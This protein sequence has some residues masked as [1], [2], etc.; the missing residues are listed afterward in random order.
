MKDKNALLILAGQV[1]GAFLLMALLSLFIFGKSRNF[2]DI[3]QITAFQFLLQV[4]LFA[5]FLALIRVFSAKLT[6]FLTPVLLSFLWLVYLTVFSFYAPV[7]SLVFGALLIA[8]PGVYMS[9]HERFALR[10]LEYDKSRV[11]ANK[12]LIHAN[13]AMFLAILL[14]LIVKA[15]LPYTPY[16]GRNL[17]L[18][19]DMHVLIGD[20]V[21]YFY[22]ALGVMAGLIVAYIF[23][24]NDENRQANGKSRET[25]AIIVIVLVVLFQVVTLSRMMVY[26]TMTLQTPSYDFGIFTQMFY[27]MRNFEGMVT[28]LERGYALNHN[29]VHISPI[30][31]LLLP[32]FWIFPRPETLQILQ[33]IVV[34]TGVIPLY[35]IGKEFQ[36]PPMIRS[37]IAIIYI[38]SPALISS[39]F[40][41]LHENCFLAPLI[42]F[43]LYFGIKKRTIPFFIS[44]LLLLL[45]KEDAGIYLVFIGL[46]FIFGTEKKDASRKDVRLNIIHGSGAIL[47]AILY[48][49][50]AVAYLNNA[51]TGAMLWRY[52]N[53]NGYPELG[54][55]GTLP[56]LF[57]NPSYLLS[58]LFQPS[59]VYSLV[60]IFATVGFFPFFVRNMADYFLLGPLIVVN[61]ASNYYWQ[62]QF[63]YQYF[64]GS[65]VLVIFLVL[66]SIKENLSLG[67][68]TR[69]NTIKHALY[70][71]A[72]V[73]LAISVMAGLD[74][75]FTRYGHI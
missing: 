20:W 43:V 64:Y 17:S 67:F 6:Y 28:T 73:A 57:Q 70:S 46:Y 54:A 39:S 33:V 72:F 61:F 9:F 19:S 8:I 65:S 12:L 37:V 45:V 24:T 1:V 68:F 4:A 30:F 10:K 49:V 51:G 34:A 3:R 40:F 60:V 44:S 31:Y 26:R 47:V 11:K 58:T 29:A 15:S 32:F 52:S 14:I 7:E 74:T 35:L 41:D 66:L 62:H 2:Y 56:S 22:I 23:Q 59:K 53:L 13:Y 69:F 16:P 18:I 25:I 38:F 55:F 21:T 75:L 42:L 50:V 63:G 5:G 27:N 71:M 48:F 36:L